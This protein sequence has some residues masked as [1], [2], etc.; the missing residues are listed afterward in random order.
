M[1]EFIE[2]QEELRP[3]S[4]CNAAQKLR[5]SA[6]AKHKVQSALRNL[7]GLQKERVFN[8]FEVKSRGKAVEPLYRFRTEHD[9][10]VLLERVALEP[11]ER[12]VR[13]QA[14][15][16]EGDQTAGQSRRAD[17]APK[18]RDRASQAPAR[19]SQRLAV[20][21]PEPRSPVSLEVESAWDLGEGSI[22]V[23]VLGRNSGSL[24]N[25]LSSLACSVGGKPLAN[26]GYISPKTG[27][28]EAFL[29]PATELQLGPRKSVRATLRF[30]LPH[31]LWFPKGALVSLRAKDLDG[32]TVGGKTRLSV[33]RHV[34]AV[35]PAASREARPT[36]R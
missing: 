28:I 24:G 25:A 26:R 1:V 2:N 9:F 20:R 30:D 3:A 19:R 29:F 31:G 12:A 33:A 13:K 15:K 16:L 8:P 4:E 35:R 21:R 10:L 22:E 14:G 5:S 34:Q 27:P 6:S 17:D 32:R 11:V 7:F 23:E 36:N 18:P